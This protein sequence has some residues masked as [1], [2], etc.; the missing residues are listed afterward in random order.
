MTDFDMCGCGNWQ[1]RRANTEEMVWHGRVY[2]F[3]KLPVMEVSLT[4]QKIE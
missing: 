2:V 3:P 1:V 4:D